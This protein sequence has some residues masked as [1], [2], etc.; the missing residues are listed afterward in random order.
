[1]GPASRRCSGRAGR[2][3]DLR[4]PLGFEWPSPDS[5]QYAPL[6]EQ[7]RRW[8]DYA[9]LYGFADIWQRPALVRGWEDM[10]VDMV[11]RPDWVHYLC[12]KFTDFYKAGLH[13]RGGSSPGAESISIS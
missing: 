7:C 5:F 1:M 8:D 9:L 11:E 13:S 4:G 6:S 3:D 12:R 2:P 10:F